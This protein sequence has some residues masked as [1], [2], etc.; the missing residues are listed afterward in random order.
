MYSMFWLN[1]AVYHFV[2]FIL[3]FGV[4]ALIFLISKRILNNYL[5]AIVSAFLFL[6]LSGYQEAVFWISS[7]GFLFTAFFAFLSILSFILWKEKKKKIYL[8]VSITSII[9]SLMFHELGVVVPFLVIVYDRIFGQPKESGKIYKL[10]LLPLAPY[11]ILRF[12]AHSHWFSG[13]YS[14]NLFKL[15]YNFVGNAIGYF[16]LNVLGPVSTPIYN[17]LRSFGREHM[18]LA[19]TMS[20]AVVL[21]LFIAYKMFFKKVAGEERKII[22]FALLFF[23]ISLAPFLG[24]GNMSSRYSYLSSFGIVLLL[25]LFVKS[26]KSYLLIYGKNIAAAVIVVVSIVFF[27]LH[28]FQLQKIHS[29]WYHAGNI[30]KRFIVSLNQLYTESYRQELVQFFFVDPPIRHGEAWVFPVGIEDALWL[31]FRNNN[32]AVNSRESL[33]PALNYALTATTKTRVLQFNKEGDGG[34]KEFNPAYLKE[35][36]Q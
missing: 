13:D 1:Q 4:V 15:P 8:V 30:S 34:F 35:I 32:I 36:G 31:T 29:D 16:A 6:A 3:H 26:L 18:I 19:F 7:T 21:V 2:S 11:L 12:V 10:L 27:S 14:Y 22:I 5:L 23:T 20:I 28:L 9:G 33:I 17:A 24:L 25:A